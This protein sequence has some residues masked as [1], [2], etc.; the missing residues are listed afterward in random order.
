MRTVKDPDVRRQEILDGAIK[1]FARKGYDKT[2]TADI[3]KELNISQGLCYRYYPT[4]EAIYDAALDKY[5]DTIVQENRQKIRPDMPI[6]EVIDQVT[7]SMENLKAAEK[8]DKSLYVIFHS[9]NSQRMHDELFLRVANKTIPYIQEHLRIVKEKG[10]IAIEDPDGAAI[11]GIYGWVG[12]CMT[13]GLTDEE[14][15]KKMHRIWYQLL[16]L[17]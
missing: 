11:A 10:E 13:S 8:E 7:G 12:L 9:E 14:R 2:T 5:A 1:I 16:E 3:S 6:R 17:S 4:K 15:M